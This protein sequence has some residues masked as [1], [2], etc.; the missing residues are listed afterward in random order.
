MLADGNDVGTLAPLRRGK[1][2]TLPWTATHRRR[3]LGWETGRSAGI[4]P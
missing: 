3:D 4:P 2:D 1:T